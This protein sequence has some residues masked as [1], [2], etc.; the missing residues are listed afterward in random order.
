MRKGKAGKKA[1]GGGTLLIPG[2]NARDLVL[3]FAGNTVKHLGVQMYA[4]RPVPAI[5][6]LI[7][8]SWDADAKRVDVTLPL[9]ET[10][11]SADPSQFIEVRDDG[12]GMTWDMVKDAYLD[13]GRDRR[14][15]EGT[16]RSPGGR[17]LQGR[18]GV[19]KLAGF[20]IADVLEV[21]TIH[22]GPDPTLGKP[23]LIWFKLALSELKKAKR[24]PA[25][26][27]LVYA[28]PV[29]QAPPGARKK[30][31]TTVVLRQLHAKKAHDAARFRR[32]MAQR[33]LMLGAKFRV[34]VNGVAL[35]PEEITLQWRFPP[36]PD[37]W[38]TDNVAGC[39]PV[40]YWIGFTH[41]PRKQNEG[42]SSGILI[43]TRGKVSQE[44]TNFEISGG[45]TGQHGL[46]YMVGMVKAEW[47]DEGVD[48]PDLI[49]T[50]RGSISCVGTSPI[51]RSC[52]Q[53]CARSR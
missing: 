11:D 33:F 36:Q 52:E 23:A 22:K 46:R 28:G 38:L 1:A 6:E 21:Q 53:R 40:S 43:Y 3:T 44:S 13:V 8:N 9:D 4:G 29:R 31:G 7:S 32:S 20:G 24:G 10:W 47:L 26:V 42:D 48:T 2:R 19:G 12:N 27:D 25:P 15:A 39:G 34:K 51:G 49:A 30:H 45:V 16:E 5:A 37:G 17:P 41:E 35:K 18:K 50:H 14:E